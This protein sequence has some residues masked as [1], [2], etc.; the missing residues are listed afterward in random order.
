MPLRK[1]I[2]QIDDLKTKNVELEERLLDDSDRLRQLE[3]D[4][5]KNAVNK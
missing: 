5:H 3:L 4:Y 1:K 2:D